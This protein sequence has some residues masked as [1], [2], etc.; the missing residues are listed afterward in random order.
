[1]VPVY[2]FLAN[3]LPNPGEPAAA[4]FDRL[5]ARSL[6]TTADHYARPAPWPPTDGVPVDPAPRHELVA[7]RERID[8]DHEL[9]TLDWTQPG[10]DAARLTCGVELAR[11]RLGI[12]GRIALRVAAE[13][14]GVAP[15]S[16]APFRPE[17]VDV[18]CAEATTLVGGRP[19]PATVERIPPAFVPAFAEDLLLD[20][21]RTLPVVV[22][23]PK[24]DTLRPIVDPARVLDE[25]YGLAHVAELTVPASTFALTNRVGKEWSCFLG[26][27]RV[28]WPGL[29]PETGDFRRHP[30][31][32]PDSYPPGPDTDRRL[33]A[34]IL[35][36]IAAA[37]HVRFADAGFVRQARA[38]LDKKRQDAVQAKIAELA[39]G[40]EE[41]REWLRLL[42]TA[43]DE[44][45]R[46]K[47][48]VE[49]TRLEIADVREQLAAQ[50]EQ[51]ATVEVEI[52]AARAAVDRERVT[53]DRLRTRVLQ[54]MRRVADAVDLAREEFRDTLEFLPDAAKSAADSP[55]QH[56]L[57][58]FELFRALDDAMREIQ[59]R[60]HLGEPLYARLKRAGFEY[61]DNISMTAEGK[62]G[63][64]Y[65]FAYR[66]ERVVFANHVT[67]GA[68]HNPQDCL[69]AH[70]YRD[71]ARKRFVVGWCGKHRTNTKT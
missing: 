2:T 65:R 38:A 6:R 48:T 8:A 42:E 67:L 64:E 71:D 68:S 5:V 70:W 54:G 30:I 28:Y 21:R 63:D 7:T 29:D 35:R 37:A 57:R 46:L 51:W 69:S 56:P 19:L 49:L 4:C 52:A 55:Y 14:F 15:V 16:A 60:G 45:R 32:F 24:P 18:L 62:F 1:M 27:V 44:N 10:A 23:S 3:F 53:S 61:K 17:L 25:V 41:S 50:K 13:G 26:A 43:W 47:E 36:R 31:F 40:A 58:V 39:A 12:Q 9:F 22:L 34:D 33:P 20:P 59:A 66:G 11:T